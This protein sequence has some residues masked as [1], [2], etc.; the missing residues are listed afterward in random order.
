MS[1]PEALPGLAQV[2]K[3]R[4]GRYDRE[5]GH[6]R[7]PGLTIF[8]LERSQTMA[9]PVPSAGTPGP[10]PSPAIDRNPIP[11]GPDTLTLATA[12]RRR[13]CKVRHADGRVEDYDAARTLDLASVA[14]PSL[15]EL[16]ALLADLAD[17]R[18]A[19]VL[20][21]A[22]LDPARS[23]GV[24]RL[25]HADPGTGEAPTLGDAPRAWVALDL[26]GLPL[27]ADVDPR[28]LAACGTAARELLP[29]PFRSAACLMA[30]TAGHGFKPGARLRAWYLLTRPL[31]AAECR[32]WLRDALVDRAALGAAQPIYTASPL[33]T[34]LADPLPVRLVRLPGAERVTTPTTTALAPAAR[35]PAPF[36]MPATGAARCRYATAAL[37]RAMVAVARAGEGERHHTAV[38]EAWGLARLV[39]GG[40]LAPTNVSRA[41]GGALRL[42]GKT[43]GEGE[44]IVSWALT[45]R[46]GGAA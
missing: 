14:A 5:C 29:A 27:P 22:I 30:A 11:D 7:F 34:G 16:A 26:D 13:L 21:G 41:I 42:A 6:H 28:D 33:F 15:D 43:E 12:R 4:T 20:R 46:C 8:P 19:C 10:I 23:R 1:R 2:P 25:L 35:P 37:E 24:R 18:D 17:R 36:A 38:R 9:G 3:P 31:T 40:L 39:T 44:R 45:R 32:R